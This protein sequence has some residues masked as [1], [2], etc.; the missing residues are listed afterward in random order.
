MAAK[1]KLVTPVGGLR[2]VF[3]DGEGKESLNGDMRY[4][5]SVRF[6]ND[7]PE[8]AAVVAQIE[9]FWVENKP[10]EA[11][12]CATN[13]IRLE[14]V[15][16]EETGYSLVNMWTGTAFPDGKAQVVNVYNAKGQK[17]NLKGKRI[18]NESEGALSGT[19]GVYSQKPNFGVVLFLG[20]V[21]VTKFKEY[22]G[23][24]G[25]EAA[26]GDFDGVDGEGEFNQVEEAD[27]DVPNHPS[28]AL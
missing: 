22:E 1:K 26:D 24:D 11:K 27:D 2:W 14:E 12:K 25:F 28:V 6:K 4:V 23:G 21:Q 10:K 13:G 18:G 9:E 8:L 5:A 15:D 3:I 19:M 16:G 7:S 17:V 20:G